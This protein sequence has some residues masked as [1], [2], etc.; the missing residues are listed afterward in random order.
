MG[1]LSPTNLLLA[2]ALLFWGAALASTLLD[3]RCVRALPLA[4]PPA[5]APE[6]AAIV[7]ARNEAHQ[8]ARCL[9]S[10]LAQDWPRLR[11][12]CVDDRSEDA[13][14]AEAAALADP[15]LT[16][17]RGSD[18]RPG[19][20]GKNHANAQGVSHA[21]GAEWL[22]FTD[23]DTEHSPPALSS[24][25]ASAREHGADLF[26]LMTDVRTETFWERALLPQVLSAVVG[27]F[28]LRLVNDP[29]SK[30]AIANG[31]YILIK[32]EVYEKVGGHAAI[33]DRVADDLELARL[34]KGSGYRLRAEMGRHL[35]S[36]RMY[37][38]LR[39]IWWGFVKNASAGAGGP[40]WALGG[41]VLVAITAFPFFG[42]PFLRGGPLTFALCV[43]AIAIAQRLIVLAKIFP[44]GLRWS[45]ALPL[46]Q[47]AF[48]GI[49]LHSAIR[50][51]RGKGPLW[52]GRAYPHGR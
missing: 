30:I 33:R 46:G 35:V 27:A 17:V 9:R 45:L 40:H 49:L 3:L 1:T 7:P 16:I 13:T 25:M 23:A 37:T 44:V 34:V 11:V 12:I 18:L 43:C 32:R 15:R 6:V 31:Q 50:Q 2:T 41:A 21:A 28:P 39:E 20:L 38:S 52:K 48:I 5:D 14:H 4:P 47:L 22:L 51:L 10:L 24:A 19:W 42:A 36:V 8:I 29:R 26:T